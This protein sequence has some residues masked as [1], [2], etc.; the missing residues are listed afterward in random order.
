MSSPCPPEF[1]TLANT[2]ADASGEV[3]RRYF[4]TPF[5]VDDKADASPVTIA[6]REAERTIRDLLGEH[7]PE[8]GIIGEEFGDERTGAEFVWI[9]DP[10][11]GTRSFISGRPI[12]G[13]LIAAACDGV[14][15]L[16]I[17]DQPISGERW[18]AG[19]GHGTTFGGAAAA[20]RACGKL[21]DALLATTSPQLFNDDE[22]SGYRNVE[23]AAKQAVFGGDCYNYGLVAAG[24]IDI[25]IESG[26]KPFDFCALAPVVT[27]SGGIMTDW[28]GAPLSLESDGDVIA[29]GDTR[30]HAE[31]LEILRAAG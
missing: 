7:R 8:D 30:V 6:D 24:F 21:A 3:I 17:I 5:S 29:A 10:I 1:L 28:Q 13:T 2:L 16:G 4:R 11:D 20:T 22:I 12:F 25:V 9:I 23:S 14:P 19:T 31:A 27:E 18:V 26:L 15:V